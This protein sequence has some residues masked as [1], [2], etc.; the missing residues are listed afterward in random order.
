MWRLKD[1]K[2]KIDEKELKNFAEYQYEN[3]KFN[4]L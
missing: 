2:R 4:D 1:E 3:A